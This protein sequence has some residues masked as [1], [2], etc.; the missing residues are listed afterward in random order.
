MRRRKLIHGFY[1]HFADNMF[2]YEFDSQV[3][4][5]R[6]M[7]KAKRVLLAAAKELEW[8]PGQDYWI[9]QETSPKLVKRSFSLKKGGKK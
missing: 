1:I 6:E 5:N 7:R 9:R 4:R 2:G 3:V 8:L